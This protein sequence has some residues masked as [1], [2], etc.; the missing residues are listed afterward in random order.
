MKEI[1]L[2]N[3]AYTVKLSKEI[4]LLRK[5]VQSKENQV[6]V[7]KRKLEDIEKVHMKSTIQ[8]LKLNESLNDIH[9]IKDSKD[10]YD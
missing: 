1:K 10:S 7:L 4:S 8:S 9:K 6:I 3:S 5:E 2:Q